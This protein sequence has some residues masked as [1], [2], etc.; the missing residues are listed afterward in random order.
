M[1]QTSDPMPPRNGPVNMSFL[2]GRGCSATD[3]VPHPVR[4]K[5]LA[6]GRTAWNTFSRHVGQFVP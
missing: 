2:D 5:G 3:I 4:S 1:V 6:A